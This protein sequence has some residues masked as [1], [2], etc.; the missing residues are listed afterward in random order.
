M[1]FDGEPLPVAQGQI[2]LSESAPEEALWR[3]ANTSVERFGFTLSLPPERG[4]E[5]VVRGVVRLERWF[6]PSGYVWPAVQARGDVGCRT[7]VALQALGL[8]SPLPPLTATPLGVLPCPCPMPTART[9]EP[10]RGCG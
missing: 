2:G 9:G 4:G 5:L 7:R 6:L 3:L 10:P 1:A 8:S